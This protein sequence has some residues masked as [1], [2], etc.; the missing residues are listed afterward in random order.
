MLPLIDLQ[1]IDDPRGSLV[2]AQGMP[3]RVRRA[4][5]ICEVDAHA[6]RGGHAHKTLDRWMIAVAGSFEIRIALRN[7]RSQM[8]RLDSPAEALHIEPMTWI[9]LRNFSAQAVCLVLASEEYDAD[10]YLRTEAEWLAV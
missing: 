10:D 2:V 6:V 8:L 7:G 5:W 1:R 9:E 4:Y 3:F